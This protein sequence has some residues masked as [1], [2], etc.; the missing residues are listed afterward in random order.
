MG[1][2]QTVMQGLLEGGELL[3]RRALDRWRDDKVAQ[4]RAAG[5]V[6]TGQA[7]R[8]A[9]PAGQAGKGGRPPGR[10]QARR[11]AL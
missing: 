10:Q 4:Q 3:R 8:Q 7:T 9:C 2:V 6:Q 1:C 11:G 5:A